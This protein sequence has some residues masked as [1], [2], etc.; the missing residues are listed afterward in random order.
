MG[1]LLLVKPWVGERPRP[2]LTTPT[3]RPPCFLYDVKQLRIRYHLAHYKCLPKHMA[4]IGFKLTLGVPWSE[5]QV[6]L[7]R[8]PGA[9]KYDAVLRVEEG[10][11]RVTKA[12]GFHSHRILTWLITTAFVRITFLRILGVFDSNMVLTQ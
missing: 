11:S 7:A 9:K 8:P 6:Y 10:H 1:L 3:S 2:P 5:N 4:R 12:A